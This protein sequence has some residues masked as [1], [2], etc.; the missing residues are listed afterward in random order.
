MERNVKLVIF[1]LDGT[2]VDAFKAVSQSVNHALTYMGYETLA[3]EVIAS[4]VG[5]GERVL[6]SRFVREGD[7]DKTLSVFRQH[8][9]VSIKSGVKFLPGAKEL[10]VDLKKKGYLIAIA[11]NRPTR[12]AHM[13]LKQLNI[14]DQFDYILCGDKVENPKPAGDL[15]VN[16]LK[17]FL[18][19][20]DQ[21]IYVGDMSID[22]QAGNNARVKTIAVTT[23]SHTY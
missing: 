20:A 12:F 7:L 17:K 10:I 8:H 11:S 14:R 2:L 9:R 3:H 5:W 15:L 21:A 19:S 22:V 16:I 6:I 13:I 4:S 23:G 1:D 18:L